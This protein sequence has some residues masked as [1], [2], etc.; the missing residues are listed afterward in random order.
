[1][2]AVTIVSS[3][4]SQPLFSFAMTHLILEVFTPVDNSQEPKTCFSLLFS[5]TS[6]VVNT[7]YLSDSPVSLMVSLVGYLDPCSSLLLWMHLL[8]PLCPDFFSHF[9]VSSCSYKANILLN[10]LQVTKKNSWANPIRKNMPDQAALDAIIQHHGDKTMGVIGGYMVQLREYKELHKKWLKLWNAETK[11]SF[12][13]AEGELEYEIAVGNHQFFLGEAEE[14]WRRFKT[15]RLESPMNLHIIG[16]GTTTRNP[17]WMEEWARL[18][19]A[20]YDALEDL[21]GHEASI[22]EGEELGV[23]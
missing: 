23:I 11:C 4:L 18:D 9:K 10:P 22:L 17:S 12:D 1:V 2:F 15:R 14:H 3:Q 21:K 6:L 20:A 7:H 13:A 16:G 5:F 8:W 19:K